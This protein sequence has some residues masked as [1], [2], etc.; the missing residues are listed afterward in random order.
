MTETKNDSQS[1]NKIQ[2]AGTSPNSNLQC[3]AKQN[4]SN[5]KVSYVTLNM[6]SE[7]LT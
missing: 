3:K 2:D 6:T 7:K 4:R 1:L 5:I